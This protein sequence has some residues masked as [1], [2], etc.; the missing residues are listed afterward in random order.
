MN[1]GYI[2]I[3]SKDQNPQRQI[4][5]I[6]NLTEKQ[7]IDKLT[8]KDTNRPQ[9]KEM[10]LFAR[11]GDLI[12]VESISRFARNTKDLLELIEL[13][14]KKEIG[15]KSLKE[16]IDTTTPQGKFMVTVFGA[17]AE[18]ELEYTRQRQREGIDIAL[19]D[20]RAYGRPK[21]L[22]D[23]EIEAAYQEYKSSNYTKGIYERLGVSKAT[24]Y[25]L[26]KEWEGRTL[27]K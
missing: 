23:E 12:I 13:L 26:M 17:V 19:R 20:K 7:Y 9:L 18:L 27:I 21:S 4:E 14:N 8:G 11:K 6:Q 22:S 16:N 5:P 10:L 24:F 1:I 3:S 15:F 2:R 25:R